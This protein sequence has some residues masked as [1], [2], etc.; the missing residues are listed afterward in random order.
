MADQI[1]WR[2]SSYSALQTDCVE[3][4]PTPGGAG[5]RDSKNIDDGE[6]YVPCTAWHAFIRQIAAS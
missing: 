3:V 5:I 6:L 1:E 4:A 2:K